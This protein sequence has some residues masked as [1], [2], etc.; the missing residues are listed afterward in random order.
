MNGLPIILARL[1]LVFGVLFG[2]N[3]ARATASADQELAKSLFYED[4]M[5]SRAG[6]DQIYEILRQLSRA[7]GDIPPDLRRLAVYQLRV[8]RQEFSP[9]MA[10]FIQGKVEEVFLK[11]GRREVVAAPELRTMRIVSTDTSF[12]MSNTLPKL[13]ELW[14]LGEKLRLDGYIEGNCTR[15]EEGDVM[16]NLR[17]FRHKTAEVVWSGTFIA[18]PSKRSYDFPLLEFGARLGFGVWPLER[19]S[20]ASGDIS[21]DSLQLSLYHYFFNLTIGEAATKS[22]SL[23]LTAYGG[24]GMIQPVPENPRHLILGQLEN[25][26]QFHAGADILWVFVQKQNT[27]EGFWLGSALGLRVFLPQ[28]LVAIHHAYSS[29]IT[30]HFT[31]SMGLQFLPLQNMLVSSESL[32]SR[33]EYELIL[34]NPTYEFTIQYSY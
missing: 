15:S 5:G 18:G 24:F 28:K 17:V 8:D 2:G 31:V 32:F 13:E 22:K 20:S 6:V 27:D 25:Y 11:Y 9:G 14:E 7:M 30:R 26:Y 10:R 34:R 23:F 19:Y 16:I 3:Y 4:Q 1:A 33:Q 12:Q 29:R 21:G